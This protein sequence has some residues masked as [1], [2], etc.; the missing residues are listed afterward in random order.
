MTWARLV[1]SELRKLT[2][3]KMPWAFLAVLIV[4]AALTATAVVIGTDTGTTPNLRGQPNGDRAPR[5]SSAPTD[6]LPAG[7]ERWPSSAEV[8]LDLETRAGA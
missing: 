8:R 5:T 4:L 1:R 7:Y 3:T 2:T 6:I